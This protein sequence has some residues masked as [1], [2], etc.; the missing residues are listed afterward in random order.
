MTIY[1]KL[2]PL[3][4]GTNRLPIQGAND[5]EGLERSAKIIAAAL[6]AG[7]SYIDVGYSYSRGFAEEAV[8]LAFQM[9]DAPRN[10]TVKSSFTVD[11]SADDAVRRIEAAFAGMGIDHATYFM[12][13]NISTYAEFLEIMKKGSLYDGA[14]KA[15]QAGLIDHICFSSHAPAPELIKIMESGVFEGAT[16]AFSTLNALTMRP[17][18][19]CATKHNIG[20]AVMNPLG[21]GV[22]PQN[23]DYF[24]FLKAAKDETVAQAA[25]RFVKAHSAI[26]ILLSGLSSQT[27]LEENVTALSSLGNETNEERKRRVYG[28]FKS[29]DGFCTGC[30]YCDGCPANI[31]IYEF[32]QAHNGILFGASP[33]YKRTEKE[34]LKSI[35]MFRKLYLD[36]QILPKTAENPCIDCGMC[37]KKCTQKL[38]IRRTIGEM[39]ADMERRCFTA[40]T[41]KLRL[42][43]LLAGKGFS[44][45]GFY[46]GAGYTAEILR[47]YR[48]Y[49]GEPEFEVLY[50]DSNPKLWRTKN[51][52]ILVHSPDDILKIKPDAILVSNYI[53]SAEIYD[54]LKRYEKEGIQILKLHRSA[55][56]PWV[57]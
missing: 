48:H 33:A 28:S 57:F 46:P 38:S 53:Y 13:W 4:I 16:I 47:L 39:Y 23:A 35:Q 45:V 10:V 15:K 9:T 41:R 56:V 36:F 44:K 24:S 27:E 30:R 14:I 37:E 1:D 11:K 19:E 54:S 40:D 3:G 7:A 6:N 50:F 20:L 34:L 32:M 51:G 25:M 12:C 43:E 29:L 17:V 5:I 2:H 18:L 22:I 31:P 8:R 21:G 26:Q 52:G 55:D 49:F 42:S